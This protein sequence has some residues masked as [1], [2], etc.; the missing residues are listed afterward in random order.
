MSTCPFGKGSNCTE[1]APNQLIGAHGGAGYTHTQKQG[2]G[3]TFG[4]LAI[5]VVLPPG[6]NPVVLRLC[7]A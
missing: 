3:Y 5:L 2:S 4:I 1:G 7:S 6:R